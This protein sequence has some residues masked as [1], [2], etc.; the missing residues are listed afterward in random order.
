M[1]GFGQDLQRLL[2]SIIVL[3]FDLEEGTEWKYVLLLIVTPLL[4]SCKGEEFRYKK[5]IQGG[6]EEILLELVG[7]RYA[8]VGLGDSKQWLRGGILESG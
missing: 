5:T 6:K 7:G 4:C 1:S 3:P 8:W 2:G